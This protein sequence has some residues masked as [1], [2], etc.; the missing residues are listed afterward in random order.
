MIA[1][2]KMLL[3]FLAATLITI[4][5]LLRLM[6]K[7]DGE[8]AQTVNDVRE[9][10]EALLLDKKYHRLAQAETEGQLKLLS[11]E[12]K[13]LKEERETNHAEIRKQK[14]RAQ[15]AHTSKGQILEKWTP[16]LTTPD[17]ESHWRVEDWSFLG[18]PIDYVV[19]DWYQD[20]QKNDAEGKV[21]L[22][23]VKAAKS[24]LTTKQRRIRDLVKR[25]SVE[26][27]EIRLD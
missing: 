10:N 9:T 25:G 3:I 26:W 19:F 22:L 4:I 18:Q 2:V 12:I 16:F 6:E 7:R 15:S 13:Q 5:Y 27:R 14:G 21:I 24:Q 17:I 11:L 23:D 8:F 20:K 1:E